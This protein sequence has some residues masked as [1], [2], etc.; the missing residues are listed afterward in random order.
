MVTGLGNLCKRGHDH[1]GSGLSLRYFH[2]SGT[3]TGNCVECG[4]ENGV[5][6][7]DRQHKVRKYQAVVQGRVDNK[8]VGSPCRV[9]HR[10]RYVL[11]GSCVECETERRR[12]RAKDPDRVLVEK[13]R[14]D[15]D[16]EKRSIKRAVDRALRAEGSGL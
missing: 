11:D 12:I 4:R 15:R 7:R 13:A 3:P 10:E 6:D 14:K 5:K 9:G 16:N 2:K 8:Y 1:E